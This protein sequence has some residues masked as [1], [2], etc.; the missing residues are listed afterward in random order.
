MKLSVLAVAR[1][2][3]R[4]TSGGAM[5]TGMITLAIVL[6]WATAPCAEPLTGGLHTVVVAGGDTLRS[7][8]SRFG[9]DPSTIARDNGLDVDARLRVETVLR[10]DNR[11]IVPTVTPE[12]SILVNVPQRMLF[13]MTGKGIAGYPIAVGR[14]DWPTPLGEFSI[15]SNE[16]NPTW[17][18]PES[19]REEARR[20]GRSLPLKVLPGPGNPLGAYWLGLSLGSVGIHGTNAP[21]SVYQRVTHGCIRLHPEDIAA[22]FPQVHVGTKGQVVY[23]PVLVA[24]DGDEVFVEAHRDVYGLGPRDALEFVR[25]RARELDV[26]ERV[27]WSLAADV[28]LRRAGVA[29]AVTRRGD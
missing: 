13:A 10:I 29:R 18:V 4:R 28:I 23:E 21:N 8:G 17:D 2:S 25:L 9:A 1:G 14:A 11:H 16:E 27:D 6:G 7:L 12:T 20:A 19:I 24:V 3:G 5:R 22:L 26:F 15:V